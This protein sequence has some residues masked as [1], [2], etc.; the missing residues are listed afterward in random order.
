[1]GI[2]VCMMIFRNNLDAALVCA[3]LMRGAT[4]CIEYITLSISGFRFNC[5]SFCA[6]ALAAQRSKAHAWT[7]S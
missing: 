5:A 6:R 4:F 2:E 3:V 1:V 7:E